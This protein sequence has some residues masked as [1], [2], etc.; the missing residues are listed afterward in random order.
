MGAGQ[1]ARLRGVLGYTP[2]GEKVALRA[3]CG[4]V[5]P[6]SAAKRGKWRNYG[7]LP[8]IWWGKGAGAGGIVEVNFS[9]KVRLLR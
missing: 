7:K 9:L 6:E 2:A 3:S 1:A 4:L 8:V 5:F